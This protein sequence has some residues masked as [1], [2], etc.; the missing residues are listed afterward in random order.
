M[1]KRI[2]EHKRDDGSIIY[3]LDQ[4]AQSGV[5]RIDSESW[6]RE[7][8][9]EVEFK[10]FT[11][12]P[13]GF[14][15]D[16]KGLTYAGSNL[17]KRLHEKYGN[18]LHVCVVAN[19]PSNIRKYRRSVKV[20]LNHQDLR[21][22][23]AAYRN[24]KYERN[25]E[26]ND[27]VE[28]FL[29]SKFPDQFGESEEVFTSYVPGTLA[30]ILSSGDTADNLSPKDRLALQEFFPGFVKSMDFS[31][32]STKNIRFAREGLEAAQTVYLEEVVEEYEQKLTRA[33]TEGTWQRLLRQHI[34]LL[35][36]SY[37]AV[38]ERQSVDIDGKFPDFMLIDPYG[39]LDIYEIKKPQTVILKYDSSRH[40][41]FWSAEICKAISQVENYIDQTTHHRHDIAEKVRKKHGHQVKIVRPRGFVIAGMR[42]QLENED[43][44]EDFRI[45]ND[46][47][48]NIDIIFY[49][50]LL[51][52]IR[53]L[54]GRFVESGGSEGLTKSGQK[55]AKKKAAR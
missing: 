42:T 27:A 17:L 16:G 5:Y 14:R 20:T 25:R 41:Y 12:L 13:S 26:L 24:I 35:L 34:L 28:R 49:D 31:L 4:E 40:N 48:K 38:I 22:V 32:K 46:S 23:N 45:L 43:M 36:H 47:L 37:S 44:E 7:Y 30:R 18:G 54:L 52:N 51:Q 50:D 33:T 11:S 10:G 1:G 8:I 53:T 2:I 19:D 9:R 3:Q 29:K 21:S 55:A 15:N 39:Y 6:Q